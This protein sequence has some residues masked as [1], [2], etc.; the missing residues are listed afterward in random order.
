MTATYVKVPHPNIPGQ[1]VDAEVL[2][3]IEATPQWSVFRLSDGTSIKVQ[4]TLISALKIDSV[5]DGTGQPTFMLNL[6][7]VIE[8]EELEG[9]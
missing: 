8:K 7:P 2:H 9:K 4:M 3:T 6:I 1:V 5:R